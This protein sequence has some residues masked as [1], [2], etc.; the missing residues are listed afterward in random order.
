LTFIV[1]KVYLIKYQD[2]QDSGLLL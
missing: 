2:F 1:I